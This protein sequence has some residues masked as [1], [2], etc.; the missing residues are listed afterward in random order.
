V[1]GRRREERREIGDGRREKGEERRERKGRRVMGEGRRKEARGGVSLTPKF[2]VLANLD[3]E[4]VEIKEIYGVF[5]FSLLS[6]F[7]LMKKK[8]ESRLEQYPR[9]FFA[10][11]W[12]VDSDPR[13]EFVM[14]KLT[15]KID[16]YPWNRKQDVCPS[17]L[18]PSFLPSFLL[19]FLP[20]PTSPSSYFSSSPLFRSP[21]PF[22]LPF[23]L[24]LNSPFLLSF[25]LS[26]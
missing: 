18:P 10:E 14:Q 11:R 15:E 23:L 4:K 8:M 13:H 7:V 6:S 25:P 5:N 16:S 24:S 21:F 17:L 12:R 22:P 2:L 20:S 1:R 26:P 19:S 3:S 9:I